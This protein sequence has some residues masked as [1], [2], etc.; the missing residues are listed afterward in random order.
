M[1][2]PGEAITDG[3]EEARGTITVLDIGGVDDDEQHQ[4]ERVR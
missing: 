3:L 2:Q 4:A 1:T